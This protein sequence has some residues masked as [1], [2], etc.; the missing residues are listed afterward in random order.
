MLPM[1]RSDAQAAV[2]PLN[3]HPAILWRVTP[4]EQYAAR[5]AEREARSAVLQRTCAHLSSTRLAL[6]V[7]MLAVAWMGW[8]AH[9]VTAA[10][11][12]VPGLAFTAVV[13]AHLRALR[14][15]AHSERQTGFYRRGIERL[16]EHWA[17]TGNRGTPL[18]LAHHLYAADLDLF[19]EGSLFEL[20]CAARLPMGE[21]VLAEWLLAP[22]DRGEIERRQAAIDD[23]T[24]R[25]DQRERIATCGDTDSAVTHPQAL[26]DWA[27]RGNGLEHTAMSA[28]AAGLPLLLLAAL[29]YGCAR[30][31]WLPA[32][33]VLTAELAV[34]YRFRQA[35][36]PVLDGIVGAYDAG[37]LRT[38]A[39]VLR[40]IEREPFDSPS[41]RA[42]RA[43]LLAD[44]DAASAALARLAWI[45][46][47]AEASAGSMFVRWFINTPLLF[48]LQIAQAAERWRRDYAAR[49][50]RWIDAAGRFEALSSLAQYRYEHPEDPFPQ[51]LDAPATVEARG[52]AHPLLPATRCVRNDL[53]LSPATP[54][55]LV[56]GS[57]MSGKSTLLRALGLNVVLAM[58]GAPVR[59]R[60]LR[61][62][63]LTI[64]ASLRAHDSLREGQSR[65][66]TEILRLRGIL[67]MAEARTALLFLLDEMLQG[68]NSKDRRVGAEGVLRALIE[69]GAVGLATTHDLALTEMPAL[70]DRIH[71]V[72]FGET[73]TAG[74]MHFDFT[75]RD[76]VTTHSNGLELMRAI[77]LRV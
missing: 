42:L 63:V 49:L 9:W 19:G 37:S 45:A 8:Y 56:S 68:T 23:L 24:P 52:L 57:N 29:A 65:F 15:H 26:L 48:P 16:E 10:W 7:L 36:R 41:L 69:L 62:S 22:A 25:L 71:N 31:Q 2:R 33:A 74:R 60:A 27:C 67:A 51:I 64:G 58:A 6:A 30:G 70:A 55:L 46:S 76:G 17:G 32:L 43:E 11:I 35:I 66:Y 12:A 1:P 50:Q 77:G 75:L 13:L 20:L 53:T 5:Q 38:L 28:L 73:I 39:D 59:A 21:R 18:D 54:V 4:H 40:H 72:H 47:L 3:S 14:L 61:V 34:L 44:G